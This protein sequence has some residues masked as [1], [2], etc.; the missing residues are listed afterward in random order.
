MPGRPTT[1]IV[2]R[3][4][5][6]LTL[7]LLAA[8]GA[9]LAH[10]A[11]RF[12]PP[13]RTPEFGPPVRHPPSA[14]EV[15]WWA[16]E[17]I[18]TLGALA[19]WAGVAV[20]CRGR[21]PAVLAFGVAAWYPVAVANV[22]LHHDVPVGGHRWHYP[23][24]WLWTTWQ[25]SLWG[26]WAVGLPILIAFR[27]GERRPHVGGFESA[28][29]DP[30]PASP[31]RWEVPAAGMCLLGLWGTSSWSLHSVPNRTRVWWWDDLPLTAPFLVLCPVFAA[32][33]LLHPRASRRWRF[34]AGGVLL[35]WSFSPGTWSVL[36]YVLR[37]VG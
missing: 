8:S 16:W 28:V 10:L 21:W 24:R 11:W 6:W 4:L 26:G 33:G 18:V 14:V 32:W 25:L 37:A 12:Y 5:M 15:R 23:P 27:P 2:S 17:S 9:V 29:A 20:R 31:V 34:A 7:L 3:L 19:V 13:G 1:G 35:L 30:T 22:Y 36:G